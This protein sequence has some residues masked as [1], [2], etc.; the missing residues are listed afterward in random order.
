MWFCNN[1]GFI[2]AVIDRDD[3]TGNTL[4]VRARFRRDLEDIFPDKEIIEDAGTDYK[5]RVF[6][7]KQ[8]LADIMYERILNIN[9]SNFKN[10][11]ARNDLHDLYEQFW[12]A[13]YNMQD[14]PAKKSYGRYVI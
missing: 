9:Y 2:S 14:K 13:G 10:S 11:V 6:V 5:Y 1:D 7:T 8:E 12:W 3:D 4:K